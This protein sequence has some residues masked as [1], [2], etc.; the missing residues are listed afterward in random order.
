MHVLVSS[1][2]GRLA[3]TFVIVCVSFNPVSNVINLENSGPKM[4]QNVLALQNLKPGHIYLFPF[5][6]IVVH[7][8]MLMRK[9][10]VI[11]CPPNSRAFFLNSKYSV[12]PYRGNGKYVAVFH[13]IRTT[14]K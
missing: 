1:V 6:S 2:L 9:N 14:K 4:L 8:L 7:N 13:F 12:G 11:S 5:C 10:I 3:I